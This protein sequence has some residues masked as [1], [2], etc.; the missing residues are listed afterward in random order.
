MRLKIALACIMSYVN[1]QGYSLASLILWVLPQWKPYQIGLRAPLPC[2]SSR[3]G[4]AA[5][6]SSFTLS[7]CSEA[8]RRVQGLLKR[9]PSGL[10][11][12]WLHAE[13]ASQNRPPQGCCMP[14]PTLLGSSCK[15]RANKVAV[16][17]SRCHIESQQRGLCTACCRDNAIL[18][19][20]HISR[21]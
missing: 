14:Q 21:H 8:S 4:A 16:S 6:S 5:Q 7:A 20:H 17:P 19:A 11:L 2:M 15:I 9:L 10:S 12:S 3:S 1:I 13:C 18:Q